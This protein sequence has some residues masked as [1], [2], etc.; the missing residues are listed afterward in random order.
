MFFLHLVF[1]EKRSGYKRRFSVTCW[2]NE[3]TE[4]T[5]PDGRTGETRRTAS[6]PT[7]LICRVRSMETLQAWM[8]SKGCEVWLKKFAKR[9][10]ETVR[11]R[12]QA[13]FEKVSPPWIENGRIQ[14]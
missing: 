8:G 10:M 14:V 7:P 4:Q 1:F 5:S 6:K 3:P 13:I 2:V 12:T 11:E 9:E